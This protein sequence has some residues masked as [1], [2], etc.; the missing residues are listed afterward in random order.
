MRSLFTFL[1][2]TVSHF[3]YCILTVWKA[4]N[5]LSEQKRQKR[6]GVNIY[7][8]IMSDIISK[9]CNIYLGFYLPRSAKVMQN[10][11]SK[12]RELWIFGHWKFCL[13]CLLVC[14]YLVLNFYE[15]FYE[16]SQ[17]FKFSIEFLNILEVFSQFF[18]H[19][20]NVLLKKIFLAKTRGR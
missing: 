16:K 6:A 19:F 12:K 20:Q 2:A 14:F 5:L 1:V 17:F 13:L 8:D 7:P 4:C 9:Y 3:G 18:E 11:G 15:K 10:C